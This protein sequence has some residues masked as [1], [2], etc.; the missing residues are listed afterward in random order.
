MLT[1]RAAHMHD[2]PG[3]ISFPGGRV[4]LTD[5]TRIETALREME[6]EVGID[7]QHVSVLGTLPEYRTGSGYRVTPVVSI[8]TP[9]FDLHANPDEVAEVF[10]SSLS[11]FYGWNQLPDENGRVSEWRGKK[12]FLYHPL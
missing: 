8:V 9:P 1:Q 5:S 7:R 6:E 2:H 4:D 10:R 11:V 3:Q 12:V